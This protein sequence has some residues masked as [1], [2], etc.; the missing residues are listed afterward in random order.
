MSE[1]SYVTTSG[2]QQVLILREG[3]TQSRGKRAQTNNISAAKMIAETVRT[4]L[5]PRG[6]D[7]MLVDSMGDVTITNDGATMLKEM[8]IQHPAAKMIVE[9]AKA[10]DNEVGDGTTSS[11]VLAG[12]LLG[13]AEELIEKGIHPMVIVNGYNRAAGQA[14]RILDDISVKV[15]PRDQATLTK[16]AR[17]SMASKMIS[18]ESASLAALVVDGLLQVAEKTAEGA[19]KVDLDNLKVEKKVGG[20]LGETRLIRGIILDKEV[21]HSGM[22]K[23]IEKA[24]IALVNSALEIEKPEFDAK[25][26]ISNPAQ[27]Q[28]FMDEETRM[29]KGMV[30]RVV[31]SGANVLICQKGIDDMAQ[32]YLAKAGILTVRRAKESDMAKL[33]KATGA[34]VV[35][36][37]EGLT[38][39]DL[40]QAGL[41]EERRIEDDKWTFIEDCKNPKAVTIF[42]RGGSQKVVDEVERSMHDAIMVVKDVL[43]KPAI[44]AGG[45][46]VEEELSQRL[47]KWS[48]TLQGREQFAAEKFAEAL[49]SIPL[50]LA[51]NAGFDP[52]D[53]QVELRE[54]HGAGKMWVGVDVLGKGARDMFEKGIIE[55]AGVKEQ[56]IKSATECTCMILRIDDVIASSRKGPSLPTG[57][58]RGPAGMEGME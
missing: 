12:A 26:N 23:R 28:Q 37:L 15:E 7:K 3:S 46:A 11:V 24:R 22:P 27:I 52:I 36:G 48:S 50:A 55:P 38:E 51:V 16:V 25:I 57:G 1:A 18:N 30:D 2:G 14:K 29:L 8:D 49:E 4:S 35:T 54:K 34:S 53:I 47:M 41:V 58:P 45:G 10:V 39:A 40:G 43:E 31:E 17:T 32:H 44:V 19:F 42:V 9:I 13:Y 6:M 20:S 33:A 21:V 56:I 5:G